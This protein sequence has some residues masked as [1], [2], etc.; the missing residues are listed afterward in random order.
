MCKGAEVV[1]KKY[2][3][4]SYIDKSIQMHNDPETTFSGE[5]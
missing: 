1:F 5:M 2:T 4:W 3:D